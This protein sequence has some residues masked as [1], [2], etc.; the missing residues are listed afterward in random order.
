MSN[1]RHAASSASGAASR[2]DYDATKT[3]KNSDKQT[4]EKYLKSSTDLNVLKQLGAPLE[5]RTFSIDQA[6]ANSLFSKSDSNPHQT[7]ASS[8]LNLDTFELEEKMQPVWASK[9]IREEDSACAV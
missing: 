8:G 1:L 7:L 4:S 9:Q 5:V 2:S 3:K 6:T